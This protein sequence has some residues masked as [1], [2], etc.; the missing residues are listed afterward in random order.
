MGPD[1]ERR[2]ERYVHRPAELGAQ[3]RRAVERLVEQDPGAAAY[4]DFLRGFYDR[5]DEESGFSP[6]TRVDAFV[7]STFRDDKEAVI[8]LH[9]FRPRRD[10][11][12][13]VLAADT[14]RSSE[15]SR[16]SVLTTLA[17]ESKDV[18]VR[19]VEDRDAGQGRLYV[20]SEPPER[21][22]H[23]IVSFPEFGLDLVADE[24]GRLAFELPSDVSSEQWTDARAVVRRPV[25]KKVVAPNGDERIPFASDGTVRG[26]RD[27]DTLTVSIEGGGSDMPSVLTAT[28]PDGIARLV[29]LDAS[30][31]QECDVPPDA[32][33]VLRLYE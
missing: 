19:I 17:A 3:E 27:E 11:G 25:S 1:D 28:P 14:D 20:L 7:E 29:R 10:S 26:R 15:K 6:S 5:L 16:F 9:P 2:I 31:P 22:E 24:E 33:L 12:P 18:V 30:V 21:R 23:V 8:S 13:T 4:A 32:P